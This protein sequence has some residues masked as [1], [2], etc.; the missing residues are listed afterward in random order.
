MDN[1]ELP[2]GGNFE[3]SP[4][5]YDQ[6]SSASEYSNPYEEKQEL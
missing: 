6:V 5:I 3:Q 1:Q 4:G 2:E